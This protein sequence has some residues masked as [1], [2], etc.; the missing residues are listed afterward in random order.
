MQT[1]TVV[2]EIQSL[3]LS[4]FHLDAFRLLLNKW[5]QNTCEFV[6]GVCIMCGYRTLKMFLYHAYWMDDVS[7]FLYTHTHT[8]IEYKYSLI[9]SLSSSHIACKQ[10]PAAIHTDIFRRRKIVWEYEIH[11][12]N[13]IELK[14]SDAYFKWFFHISYVNFHFF[15]FKRGK[16]SILME[17]LFAN[18]LHMFPLDSD[19]TLNGVEIMGDFLPNSSKLQ[20]KKL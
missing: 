17:C 1:L 19:A 2:S 5:V 16:E 10:H 6:C 4:F 15:H 14:S 20:W 13:W 3:S 12:V 9:H 18:R 11:R 8:L 7:I